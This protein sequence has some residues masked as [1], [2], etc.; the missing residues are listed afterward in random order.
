MGKILKYWPKEEIIKALQ[1]LPKDKPIN[2]KSLKEYYKKKLICWPGMLSS[3]FGTLKNACDEAGIRCDAL[4]G[5]EKMQ[6]MSKL[7]TKWNKKNLIKLIRKSFKNLD[8][9][10]T[11]TQFGLYI[12]RN[13]LCAVDA[14]RKHFDTIE[15]ALIQAKVKYR[16]YHWSTERIITAL[17]KINN[18]YG[19]LCKFEINKKFNKMGL[20]CKIKCIRDVVGSVEDAARLA[21]FEFIE[22]RLK[23]HD[24][25][26]KIGKIETE[27][28]DKIE[29]EKGIKLERQHRLEIN[30][31]VY[32][33]DG[34]DKENNI[35]YEIDEKH[36]NH[37]QCQDYIKDKDIKEYLNCEVIRIKII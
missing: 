21:G 33:I 26:G 35:A 18:K 25:N 31:T 24:F 22:P 15:N 1:A 23:G 10:T 2:K 36:H 12:K 34:Y 16:N 37:T 5:K 9:R 13:K 32:F 8:E 11:P 19:P 14:F 27:E 3:K 28:L 20:I 17:K 6:Y 30:D 7:N 29:K 4:Y